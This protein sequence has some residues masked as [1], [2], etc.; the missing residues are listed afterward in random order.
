MRI[1]HGTTRIVFL[2][3]RWAL[4]MPNLL[5]GIRR[6]CLAN[7]N[8]WNRWCWYPDE[9]LCPVLWMSSFGLLLV[10]PRAALLSNED[11]WAI[12]DTGLFSGLPP[13]AC[14]PANIG[15][16]HGRPVTFDYGALGYPPL[17]AERERV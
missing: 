7:R 14:N 16:L 9:R 4:K 3:G 13:D 8:E 12:A 5:F 15:L 1:E 2:I 10:M 17:K 6:G 11:A